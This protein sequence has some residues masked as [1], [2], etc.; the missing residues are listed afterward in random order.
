MHVKKAFE[1]LLVEIP[2]ADATPKTFLSRF[3]DNFTL[4]FRITEGIII[5]FKKNLK[6]PFKKII[7]IST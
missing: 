4:I 1:G 3:L 5:K 6:I 7:I 2:S